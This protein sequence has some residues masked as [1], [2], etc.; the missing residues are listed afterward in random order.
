MGVGWV[1]EGRSGTFVSWLGISNIIIFK[2][3][4]KIRLDLKQ[5]KTTITEIHKCSLKVHV[6]FGHMI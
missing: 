4:M 1:G 6:H 2:K 3:V 5:I